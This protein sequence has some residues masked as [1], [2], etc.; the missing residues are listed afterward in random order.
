M[1]VS[2]RRRRER[3]TRGERV[4]PW[5]QEAVVVE[6]RVERRRRAVGIGVFMVEWRG[7]LLIGMEW[8]EG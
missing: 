1:S 5:A 2:S 8:G 7:G 3:G 6:M 4:V